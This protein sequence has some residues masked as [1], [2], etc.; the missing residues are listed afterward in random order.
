[1][2]GARPSCLHRARAPRELPRGRPRFDAI[3]D[4]AGI[5]LEAL[6]PL[7]GADIAQLLRAQAG[8]YDQASRAATVSLGG[9]AREGEGE[10]G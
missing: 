1:L 9:A 5:A 7:D 8:A 2:L 3:R 6:E 4:A 10:G